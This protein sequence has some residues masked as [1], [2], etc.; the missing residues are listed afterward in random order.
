LAV[1][2][3]L[4]SNL[5]CGRE[6]F[7][8]WADQ[9]VTEVIF[10]K[11]RDP[12]W[13]LD[14]FSAEP[15]ALSR[16]ADPYD[17]DQPPA[18]PDDP[19]AEA[20]SPVPQ[21]PHNRLLV[22]QEGTGYNQ[23]L[24]A[25][26]RY[27][28]PPGPGIPELEDTGTPSTTPP[29]PPAGP[30][31][32]VPGGNS[33]PNAPRLSPMQG[34][35][36]VPN[37]APTPSGNSTSAPKPKTS[38]AKLASRP[39]AR[40]KA[41]VNAKPKPAA[42]AAPESAPLGAKPAE[43]AASGKPVW[44]PRSVKQPTVLK[45]LK[46]P[47]VQQTAF[48]QAPPTTT[49]PPATGDPGRAR[50]EEGVMQDAPFDLNPNPGEP[51]DL[52]A[53]AD[54][55]NRMD[56]ETFKESGRATAGLSKLLGAAAEVD[57][58][59]AS[60]LAIGSR[61]YIVTPAQA[62]NLALMNSRAYQSQLEQIYLTAIPVTLQ[63]FN[64][65]P[66]F[67]AG[68]SPTNATSAGAPLSNFANT[69][70]YRTKEAPG[71]QVSTL[72]LG[73]VAGFGKVFSGGGKLLAGFASQTLFNFN[74]KNGSQPVQQSILPLQF[75]QPFLAGGGRAVTLEPLTLAER[76]LLYQI[77]L[78]A[79]FRQEFI[80]AVL[81][82]SS[83]LLDQTGAPGD[84]VIGYLSVLQQ[85]QVVSNSR[86]TLEAY[87][88]LAK[89]YRQ[90]ASGVSD[91]SQLNLDQIN[92]Q[93]YNQRQT[94][95]TASLQYRNLLDQ[96][97]VQL[98][99]P[100]DVPLILDR[101]VLS[102][103]RNVFKTIDDWF[104]DEDRVPETLPLLVSKLPTLENVTVDGRSI[105]YYLER[106]EAL[107]KQS[108]QLELVKEQIEDIPN[109]QKDVVD[110]LNEIR[111]LEPQV[112]QLPPDER[113]SSS[114]PDVK[115]LALARA[116][117]KKARDKL[118]VIGPRM[119]SLVQERNRLIATVEVTRKEISGL[120]EEFLLAGE[121]VALENRLDLM[122][123]RAQ[124]YDQ[125]R[126]LAVTANG[127]LGVFNVTVTNQ[128]F[129]PPTTTNPFAFVDQ[130]KQFQMVLN[131]ELPLVRVSQRNN[132][133]TAQI[134]YHRQQRAL[135]DAE[136]AVKYSIRLEI[137]TLLQLAQSF[138][139]QKDTLV[140]SLRNKDNS[141]R[142]LFAPPAA[143]GA[144]SQTTAL[145]SNLVSAQNGILSAQNGLIGVWVSYQAGRFALY[146]DLGIIPY[147]EWEA[148]YELFPAATGGNNPD[149]PADAGPPATGPGREPAQGGP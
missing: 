55:R 140:I 110:A 60:G 45:S 36:G 141:V 90:F 8:Q 115:S 116:N 84:S 127:L 95:V 134:N 82:N 87:T 99:L 121:R 5:G 41:V 71:G 83:Q 128:Y 29:M 77:R 44:A 91:I 74:Q 50:R 38:T 18:P 69:F 79:R 61:P 132:F 9:D 76:N 20:T 59:E 105:E 32:F 75:F 86:E 139:I 63:R 85:F 100:P 17:I 68:L 2:L 64:F 33:G 39:A 98:G 106:E 93:L 125:W 109:T 49:T 129:T 37:L 146:R 88:S 81:T 104:N 7:R 47:G 120:L 28:S 112:A 11:S 48:F 102:G 145:T 70:N 13:R 65:E 89:A 54:P 122:N 53:P 103:F 15:P 148:Y 51:V 131:A 34:G 101:S 124:L 62:V 22:P 96:Y 113:D 78:F 52:V 123:A 80:P 149:A 31:P 3:A 111:V 26:P 25:G 12:R 117:L 143:G 138:T 97:K 27:I 118:A 72:S 144:A 19:A 147:D 46:D 43:V 94:L 136:D 142:Q 73:T 58:A 107:I 108:E 23:I 24:E 126:Q 133:R 4:G 56:P 130:A 92:S 21:W 135:Q 67:Y 66:Q 30:S 114:N 1:L 119:P 40:P 42:V 57:E 14:L 6:F 137:R 10:E 35:A 16:F